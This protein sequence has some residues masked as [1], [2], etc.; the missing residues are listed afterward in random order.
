MHAS[1]EEMARGDLS[2]EKKGKQAGGEQ[3]QRKNVQKQHTMERKARIGAVT[4]RC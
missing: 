4:P 1:C 3:G 2:E